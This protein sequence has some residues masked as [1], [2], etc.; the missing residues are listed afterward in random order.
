MSSNTENTN[1][2][3]IPAPYGLEMSAKQ[4]HVL[5]KGVIALTVVGISLL[6][7]AVLYAPARAE[8]IGRKCL[9]SLASWD[10]RRCEKALNRL[11]VVSSYLI[12][13]CHAFAM[14]FMNAACLG[15]GC[16][17]FFAVA[18]DKSSQS[19]GPSNDIEAPPRKELPPMTRETPMRGWGGLKM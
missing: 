13:L 5:M 17:F 3:T 10:D 18:P 9:A 6:L 1:P 14:V 11:K 7:F 15:W 8:I 16:I 4:K 12:P 19:S 2:A